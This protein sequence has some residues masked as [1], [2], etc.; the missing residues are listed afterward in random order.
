[1]RRY[2]TYY[3][4]VV[5]LFV[6]AACDHGLSPDDAEVDP[7][8]SGTLRISGPWAPVDSVKDFRVVAF[9]NY[10]PKDILSEVVLGSAV[11]SDE[12]PYGDAEIQYAVQDPALDGA[13]AYIVVAQNY[14]DDPFQDWRAVGVYTLTGDVSKPSP[15]DLGSGSFVEGIDITVDFYNLPPQPF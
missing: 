2:A 6:A 14:G 5:F 13:F 7:G 4:S 11:F 15:V 1:M 8:F 3:L 10:P 9:R 12:L